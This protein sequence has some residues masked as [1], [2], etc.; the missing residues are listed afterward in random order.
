LAKVSGPGGG[1]DVVGVGVGVRGVDVGPA[2]V[3]NRVGV[4]AAVTLLAAA[5]G[6]GAG[7]AGGVVGAG[8]ALT[9]S[10]ASLAEATL[11]GGALS[12]RLLEASPGF[13]GAAKAWSRPDGAAAAA[14][15][16]GITWTTGPLAAPAGAAGSAGLAEAMIWLGVGVRVGNVTRM[17]TRRDWGPSKSPQARVDIAKSVMIS[18]MNCLRPQKWADLGLGVAELKK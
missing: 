14:G 16:T 10:G 8:L 17:T 15:A 2:R 4:G 11:G 6:N 5:P 7:V 13:D 9:G 3:G 1:A 18:P 12:P